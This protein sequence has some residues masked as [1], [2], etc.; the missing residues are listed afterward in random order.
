MGKYMNEDLRTT[1]NEATG[2]FRLLAL[3][4]ALVKAIRGAGAARDHAAITL[5]MREVRIRGG[6]REVLQE[7]ERRIEADFPG[8]LDQQ[9]AGWAMMAKEPATM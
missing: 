7:L 4:R 8:A 5:W 6:A 2:L 9:N 3:R 1:R